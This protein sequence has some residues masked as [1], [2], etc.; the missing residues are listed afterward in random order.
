MHFSNPTASR[1]TVCL[2]LFLGAPWLCAQSAPPKFRTAPRPDWVLSNP[3]TP[4][5]APW[6]GAVTPWVRLLDDA[7]IRVTPGSLERYFRN[8]DQAVSQEGVENIST[9]TF[10]FDPAF[11]TLTIHHIGIIRGNQTLVLLR[12]G[13]ISASEDDET[14]LETTLKE[15][16]KGDIVD[17][18]YTLSGADPGQAGRF[19]ETLTLGRNTS[20]DRLRRRLLWPAQRKLY[21]RTRNTAV[22]PL[23]RP[24]GREVEYL[25]EPEILA[26]SY[27]PGAPGWFDQTPEVQLSDFAT[28]QQVAQQAA[29]WYRVPAPLPEV[30]ARQ[31]SEWKTLA[32]DE[33]RVLAAVRFVQD[34][35]K[36]GG[37]WKLQP[38]APE[39]VFEKREGN[40]RD[41]A[42]LLCT[43]LRGLG[44]EAAPALVNTSAQHA[45]E[46]Y[47]PSLAAF[48]SAVVLVS[49]GSRNYWFDPSQ[50][51]QRGSLRRHPNPPYARAL[52][53]R[54]DTLGL[55]EIP[56]PS[57]DS[58]SVLIKEVYRGNS[59]NE[60]VSCQVVTRYQGI[61]ADEMRAQFSWMKP[62]DYSKQR[63]EHYAAGHLTVAAEGE[64]QVDDDPDANELTITERYRY[65]KFWRGRTIGFQA[66]QVRANLRLSTGSPIGPLR[67][68]YPLD[69]RQVIELHAPEPLPVSKT[70]GTLE[71]GALRL[72]Y[73]ISSDQKVTT[74]DCRLQ[75]LRSFVPADKTHQHLRFRG[76]LEAKL[77]MQLTHSGD[78]LFLSYAIEYWPFVLL[79]ALLLLGLALLF[80]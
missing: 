6:D 76:Q 29:R 30:L 55:V 25:W 9:L 43:L 3:E 20:T 67:L 31:V 71:D 38:A 41:Q 42:L 53:L 21:I 58:S 26:P 72:S 68:D 11:Q 16:R 48:D 32:G 46:A 60:P 50:K 10:C 13:E 69:F 78:R 40:V 22:A 65:P 18:S 34:E 7:Q 39:T 73:K 57:M 66:E 77:V 62:A 5:A 61:A 44:I 45:I 8:I 79:A 49:L 54:P 80:W 35:I 51:Y 12:P 36:W 74:L 17:Y 37:I 27:S 1:S 14:C 19:A 59:Y 28:W 56:G 15:A 23:V 2:L 64:P 47:Q 24:L 52:L 33:A 63:K 75:S 4:S 70:A